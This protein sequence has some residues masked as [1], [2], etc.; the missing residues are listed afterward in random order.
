MKKYQ[1]WNNCIS[2]YI[3]NDDLCIKGEKVL[4]ENSTDI[5]N[6]KKTRDPKVDVMKGILIILVVIGHSHLGKDWIVRLPSFISLFHMP[7]FFMISGY[8]FSFN[9]S[10]WGDLIGYVKRKIKA[11]WVPYFLMTVIFILLNNIFIEIGFYTDNQEILNLG[12]YSSLHNYMTISEMLKEILKAIFFGAHVELGGTFW[13]F[14]ALFSVTCLY[15]FLE[16]CINKL[17]G[18][19][20]D[21]ILYIQSGISVLFLVVGYICSICNLSFG[22]LARTLSIYS[23]F[24]IGRIIK[25]RYSNQWCGYNRITV[26]IA[27]IILLGLS[28]WGNIG[29]NFNSYVNPIFLIIASVTGWCLVNYASDVFLRYHKA[30][31]FLNMC[32]R[33]SLYIMVFHLISFKLVSLLQIMIYDLPLYYV[34]SFPV[35]YRNGFWAVFYSIVGV[36]IPL[37]IYRCKELIFRKEQRHGISK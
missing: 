35:L 11:L 4:M 36:I 24:H 7:C 20:N 26:V 5:V 22:G 19:Q 2:F 32:G 33:A 23:L 17:I 29:L 6:T 16:F 13:F 21:W 27:V 25:T 3:T 14:K 10:G 37:V 34:A 28:F 15:Y 30:T 18:N 12:E 8:L 1:V 31:F 9:R